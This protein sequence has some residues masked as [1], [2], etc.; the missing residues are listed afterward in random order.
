MNAADL[1]IRNGT[2][3]SAESAGLADVVISGG[4]VQAL[5]EPGTPVPGDVA[6]LDATG[7]LVLPGGVDPHCHVGFTSGVYTT[8][9]DYGQ[10]T[11]AAVFGG[12]TTIADFAIFPALGAA[13]LGLVL[14][15]AFTKAPNKEHLDLFHGTAESGK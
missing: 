3:V 12:T 15:S 4:R 7:R 8:L 9:D 1:V 5:A 2:V 6:E 13:L 10:A 11:A 14:V